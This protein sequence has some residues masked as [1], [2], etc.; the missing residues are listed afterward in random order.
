MLRGVSKRSGVDST[1][2]AKRLSVSGENSL[3]VG[4]M[5]SMS[6]RRSR[7]LVQNEVVKGSLWFQE[8]RLSIV[9]PHILQLLTVS[10]LSP[11]SKIFMSSLYSFVHLVNKSEGERVGLLA[12]EDARKER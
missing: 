3:P 8:C 2:H 1:G 7:R 12:V 5:L 6:E 11:S 9:T 10:I 4:H